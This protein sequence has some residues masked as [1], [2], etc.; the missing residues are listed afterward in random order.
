MIDR[1]TYSVA[2]PITEVVDPSAVAIRSDSRAFYCASTSQGTV[3]RLEIPSFKPSKTI[4]IGF[5]P[6]DLK[7][8]SDGNYLFAVCQG[9]DR[10]KRGGSQ[11]VVIDTKSD[12]IFW[13]L[14]NVGKAPSS[15]AV[16]PDNSRIVL[17]FAIPSTNPSENIKTFKLQM[18][19]DGVSLSRTGGY[20]FGTSP[21]SNLVTAS[22]KCWVGSDPSEGIFALDLSGDSILT[23][24]VL[25]GH[26]HPE[27]V[28]AVTIDVAKRISDMQ[29]KMAALTD[30]SQIADL[31]L[32]LAYLYKTADRRNDMVSTYKKVIDAIP[33]S[34]AAINAGLQLANICYGDQLFSQSAEYDFNALD[35]YR[36]FLT[37]A[38]S[39]ERLSQNTLVSSLDRLAVLSKQ[40]EK[41][42]LQRIATGYLKLT[43]KNPDLAAAYFRLG[44]H[45]RKIDEKKL[46]NQCFVEVQ[47]QLTSIDDNSQAQLLTAGLELATGSPKALYKFKDRKK[48]PKVDGNL[49]E[50]AKDKPLS[51]T[52]TTGFVFGSAPWHGMNDLTA[53]L[54]FANTATDIYVAGSI[55][56]DSLVAIT[57]TESDLVALYFDLRPTSGNYFARDFAP[58]DGCFTFKIIAPTSSNPKARLV[59]D[60]QAPYEIASEKTATGYN[61][62]LKL[63]LSS[64][65]GWLTR[66]TKR[67][68]F[69]IELVDFDNAAEAKQCKAIGFLIPTE[70]VAG[71]PRPEL[72]GVAEF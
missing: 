26:E 39:P 27:H 60:T 40:F 7:M 5:S 21:L 19:Q 54:Y 8:S 65:G 35:A 15:I 13:V 1:S 16:S 30:S 61:F 46:A 18:N 53:D 72:Y 32:D 12:E 10:G 36:V 33:T 45:L 31:Y 6:V 24:S 62:E 59:S 3:T 68:G 20:L 52:G 57:D 42:Y 37:Q 56:D 47:N 23:T 50:W 34:F 44:Y 25:F 4:H 43:V 58:G 69:G 63:P 71:P 41:D 51:L 55:S 11:V 14:D 67:F 64:F 28:A 70:G 48:E 9:L 2:Y 22:G 38:I 17:T 49:G 66:E 29:T